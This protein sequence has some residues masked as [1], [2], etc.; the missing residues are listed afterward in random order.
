MVRSMFSS[1]TGLFSIQFSFMDGLDAMLENGLCEDGLS[2]IATKL[3]TPLMLDSYMSDMYMQSWGRLRYARAMIELQANVELKDNIVVAIPKIT[4][5]CS[6]N[7]GAGETKNLKKPSQT[8]KG[9]LVGQKMGKLLWWMMRE[10]RWKRLSPGDYDSEDEVASVDNEMASFFARKDGYGTNTLL[11]QWNESYENG[12]YDYDP[13]DDDISI[14]QRYS[15]PTNY[16]LRSS[17]NTRNQDLIQDGHVDIQ[18]KNVGYAGNGNRNAG[19]QNGNKVTNAGNG[20]CYNCNEKGHYARECPKPRVRD[21]KYF[22]EQMLLATKDEAGVHL[23]EDENDFMLD[24]AYGDNT[25]NELNVALIMMA[26]IQ[27]TDDK[28]DA[29]PTYDAEFISERMF[30]AHDWESKTLRNFIEKFIGI[31]LFGNDKFAAFTGYGDYV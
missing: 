20:L 17:S 31:V 19:R 7:I 21:S 28:T 10:N 9:V 25:L 11:E 27:P 29:K 22:R 13:Y 26:C 30:K 23:D 8:P 12:D 15:T 18:S 5:E 14:T 2:A 6:K 1:S 24:N 3:G 16:R 4:E